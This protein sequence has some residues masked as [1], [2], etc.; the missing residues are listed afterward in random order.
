LKNLKL[1]FSQMQVSI[2][3]KYFDKYFAFHMAKT[4]RGTLDL[5]RA[6]D[7]QRNGVAL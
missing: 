4:L 2:P 3:K 5:N 1:D 7:I 6:F